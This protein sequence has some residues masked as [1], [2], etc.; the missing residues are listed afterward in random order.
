MP[1][2]FYII[3]SHLNTVWP[4][5]IFSAPQSNYPDLYFGK[6]LNLGT[7]QAGLVG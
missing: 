2:L 5:P 6:F 1:N 7:I 4:P 3:K